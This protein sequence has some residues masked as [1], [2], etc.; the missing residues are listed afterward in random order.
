V[1]EFVAC[2]V[3]IAVKPNDVNANVQKLLVWLEKAVREHNAELIVFPES[4]TT[5]F[6]PC[7]PAGEV[8]EQLADTV[9]GKITD[10]VGQAARRFGVH[11]VLPM[12][13]RGPESPIVYNS[14]VLIG[15]DG[16]IIG[17]YRKT[18]PFPTERLE[19]GGWTTP[20]SEAQVFSTSLGKI[21]MIICYD[22][23]FPELAREL[24]VKGAEIITRP[25]AFLRSFDI[26]ELTCRARAYDN[27][28]YLI[29]VN[30]VGPD[31]GNNYYAG[32]SMIV[33]PIAQRLAQARGTEEIISARLSPEPLQ[34]ISYGSKA[35]MIFDHVEDRNLAVY[36]NILAPARCAFE[37]SRR[38]PYKR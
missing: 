27:H 7:M 29:G 28:V 26:W 13:E 2:G 15:P 20:G 22:G 24:T 8:Y 10:L 12:Y 34:Y 5:G 19:G 32:H 35:P 6:T 14:S 25:S 31:G 1:R 36:E 18:H 21:G 38:I 33:S 9:P 37:P 23:D 17:V 3:Q 30:A 4:I 16:G 11:V